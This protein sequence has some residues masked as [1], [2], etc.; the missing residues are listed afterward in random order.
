M[1]CYGNSWFFLWPTFSSREFASCSC[2]LQSSFSL[3]GTSRTQKQRWHAIEQGENLH[4]QNKSSSCKRSLP[5]SIQAR[6]HLLLECRAKE[7]VQDG[8]LMLT[9]QGRPS[10]DPTSKESC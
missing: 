1:L 5:C 4:I 7:M 6:L 10:S 3:S 9:L 8:H 2:F